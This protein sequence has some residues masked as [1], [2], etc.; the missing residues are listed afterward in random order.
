MASYGTKFEIEIVV[1]SAHH[2]EVRGADG[3][4][5]VPP[6]RAAA[7]APPA[8]ASYGTTDFRFPLVTRGFTSYGLNPHVLK[9][10]SSSS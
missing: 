6:S 2:G 8:G 7:A 4:A 5:S 3:H 1:S 9:S 10:S